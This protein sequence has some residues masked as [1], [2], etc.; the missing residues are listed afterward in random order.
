M[1]AFFRSAAFVLLLAGA[2]PTAVAKDLLS[3]EAFTEAFSRA[4]TER[5]PALAIL[6]SGPLHLTAKDAAG[7]EFQAFLD[8]AYN[9]Y[10]QDPAALDGILETYTAGLVE[11]WQ[12]DDH[13]D[14]TRI[15]PVVKDAAYVPDIRAAMRSHG[16]NPDWEPVF[17]TYNEALVILYAEDTERNIRYMGTSEMAETGFPIEGRLARA[18]ANLKVLLPKLQV[19][20]QGGFY[21][22]TAGGDYDASLLLFDRLWQNL[23]LPIKGE[24]V[25]AVPARNVLVVTGTEESQGLIAL[26]HFVAETIASDSY[27][28]TDQLFVYRDG[29]FVLFES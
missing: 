17:E 3:E 11:T 12:A 7:K 4:L 26:K 21:W 19:Y 6:R 13:I 9:N 24:L 5:A 29:K 15:V 20:D 25:A 16:S 23:K 8:N 18:L 22:V 2:L 1:R 27:P 28:L 10:R 14:T